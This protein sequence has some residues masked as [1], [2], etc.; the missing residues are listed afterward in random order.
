MRIRKLVSMVIAV[1]FVSL[2][3]WL[4][5]AEA[6]CFYPSSLSRTHYGYYD[7]NGNPHCTAIISPLPTWVVVGQEDWNCNG[8]YSTS[9]LIC[10][11]DY[12]D[13]YGYCDPI[14]P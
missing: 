8:S 1:A 10:G 3:L 5:N 11:H 2:A 6:N 12:Q 7:I 14:C 13:S 4:P 9:G